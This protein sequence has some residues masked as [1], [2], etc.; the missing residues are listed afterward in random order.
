MG[1]HPIFESDF[2]CLTEMLSILQEACDWLNAYMARWYYVDFHGQHRAERIFQVILVISGIIGFFYGYATESMQN[3][4]I[5]L[6][7]G[8][9]LSSLITVFPW[10]FLRPQEKE[11]GTMKSTKMMIDF[12]HPGTNE[13]RLY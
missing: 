4:M 9:G 11:N 6:G 8:L 7:G 1:T 2:D 5:V 12:I 10:P 3:S 13:N